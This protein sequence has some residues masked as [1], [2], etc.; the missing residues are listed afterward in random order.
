MP[1]LVAVY[2]GW[3]GAKPSDLAELEKLGVEVSAYNYEV[4]AF[5]RCSMPE[6]AYHAFVRKWKGYRVW[7]LI[8]RLEEVYTKEEEEEIPF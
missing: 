6:A 7:G 8:R 4:G 3:I 5:D 2:Q 1:K